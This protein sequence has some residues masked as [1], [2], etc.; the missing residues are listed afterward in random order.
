MQARPD[1][2]KNFPHPLDEAPFVPII[3]T[4]SQQGE[5]QDIDHGIIRSHSNRRQ[6]V[7]GGQGRRPRGA[8]RPEGDVGTTLPL[9]VLALHNGASLSFGTPELQGASVKAEVVEHLRGDKLVAFKKKRRKGYSR[10]IGHRQELTKIRV[11]EL[12]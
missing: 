8:E 7:P 11:V 5:S 3:A 12:G 1:V 10:R 4:L 2:E 9:T 6:A